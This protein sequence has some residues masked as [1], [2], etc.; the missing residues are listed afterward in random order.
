MVGPPVRACAPV[1][2]TISPR[3]KDQLLFPCFPKNSETGNPLSGVA[4]PVDDVLGASKTES[5]SLRN[6]KSHCRPGGTMEIHGIFGW[7]S[8]LFG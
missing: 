6:Q 5:G 3:F 1:L 7:L 2:V 8:Q 4:G